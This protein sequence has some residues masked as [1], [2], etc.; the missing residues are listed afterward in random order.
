MAETKITSVSRRGGK[1][2]TAR[3]PRRE[4][5]ERRELPVASAAVAFSTEAESA[6]AEL[7]EL[8]AEVMGPLE[9]ALVGR[10]RS[11]V[12]ELR[13]CAEQI[14]EDGLLVAGSMGQQ[15]P[16]PLLKMV[17]DLRRE[18]AEG[19]KELDAHL[20]LAARLEQ[21]NRLAR[22]R[23]PRLDTKEAAKLVADLIASKNAE[24]QED[25]DRAGG[26]RAGRGSGR[27]SGS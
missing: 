3:A 20:D 5:R 6:L 25:T 16:H 24:G 27:T 13:A 7:A 26:E 18:V 19:L 2:A 4:P 10:L 21:A 15:R 1:A 17:G 14:G 12:A 11:A 9:R 8:R 23:R 22:R